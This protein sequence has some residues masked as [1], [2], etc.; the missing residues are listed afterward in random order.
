MKRLIKFFLKYIPRPVLIK[1]SLIFRKP[2]SLFY[3]GNHVYCPVCNHSF[4]TFL[5]YGYGNGH[6]KNRLCPFC[7]SLERHRLLWLYL[8]NKSDFFSGNKNVLHFAPEQPF[9]KRFRKILQTDYI[10]T[11]LYSPIV[12]V[13]TDIRNLS[14]Q[15]NSF[16][17]IICNHVLEHIDDE[18]KAL[19]EI[20]R[21]LKPGAWAILQVPINYDLDKTFEDDAITNPKEREKIFGQYDH[22]R[23]YGKDYPERLKNAGFKVIED[24]FVKTFSEQE[25]KKYQFDE[26]EII[27]ICIKE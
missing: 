8:N 7:L 13:K 23:L 24:S 2:V 5:P 15:S 3:R 21:V 12:D 18:Q 22:V 10:T 9:F 25:I 11:D 6:K 14:F 16:D 19:Y 17:I 26:N 1:L 4:R 27:Y 20:K